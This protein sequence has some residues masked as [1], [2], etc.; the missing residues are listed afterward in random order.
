MILGLRPKDLTFVTAGAGSTI[1]PTLTGPL[2][3][4]EVLGF[5][6]IVYLDVDATPAAT[7]IINELIDDTD[8]DRAPVELGTRRTPSVTRIAARVA[9]DRRPRTGQEVTVGVDAT[10]LHFFDPADGVAIRS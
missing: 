3:S 4:V 9:A 5:E 10:Q 2:R 6:T 1:R 7:E 8:D